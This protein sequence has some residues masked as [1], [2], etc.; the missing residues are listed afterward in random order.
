MKL[1]PSRKITTGQTVNFRPVELK[2]STK[3]S[4]KKKPE[5][6]EVQRAKKLTVKKTEGIIPAILAIK[7]PK[8]RDNELI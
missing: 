3:V 1:K 7:I 2:T 6:K 4:Y 5:N 8:K